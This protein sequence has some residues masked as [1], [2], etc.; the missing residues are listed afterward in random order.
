MRGEEKVVL[1]PLFVDLQGK[2]CLVVG[3]GNVAVRKIETLLSFGAEIFVV[4]PEV[5]EGIEELARCRKLSVAQRSYCPSDLEGVSLAIAATN[6]NQVNRQVYMEAKERNIPVN[7]VDKPEM[8]TF[9]F[10]SIVKRQELVIGI[11]TSGGFPALS[12][13]IRQMLEKVIPE[14]LGELLGFLKGIRNRLKD[15]VESP[16]E[17]K[18]LLERL[19]DEVFTC[20]GIKEKEPLQQRIDQAIRKYKK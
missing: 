11:S 15:E 17:R 16:A 7:V 13:R 10:P 14:N 4:S 1:F 18:L 5:T 8:C 20:K 3:G 12:K 9:V 19:L 6:V 2:K